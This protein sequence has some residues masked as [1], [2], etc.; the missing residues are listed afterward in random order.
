MSIE[1]FLKFLEEGKRR[2]PKLY[3]SEANAGN[4]DAPRPIV[5]VPKDFKEAAAGDMDERE[6]EED[7]TGGLAEAEK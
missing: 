5:D 6:I 3:G 4:V 1:A 7:F 2:C